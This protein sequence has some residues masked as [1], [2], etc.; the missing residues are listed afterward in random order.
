MTSE[1]ELKIAKMNIKMVAILGVTPI[2]LKPFAMRLT[3]GR[4]IYRTRNFD[5]ISIAFMI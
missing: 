4:N 2:L 5:G 3:N 1:I